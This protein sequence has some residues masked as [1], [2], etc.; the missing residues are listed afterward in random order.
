MNSPK[1]GLYSPVNPIYVQGLI[2]MELFT[3][4]KEAMKAGVL[5]FN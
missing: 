2:L 1:D 3:N 5:A 4:A